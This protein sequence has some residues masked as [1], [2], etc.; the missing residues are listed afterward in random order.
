[1]P[2]V[3]QKDI[4]KAARLAKIAITETE[5]ETFTNQVGGIINW[6]EQLNEVNTD[7]VAALTNVHDMP[8]RMAK[9]E[10]SDGGISDDVLKNSKHAK[11]EYFAVPKVIE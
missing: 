1:M 11:Y 10:I 8:L 5:C 7:N 3:T 2:Q 6:V 9:D 4:K